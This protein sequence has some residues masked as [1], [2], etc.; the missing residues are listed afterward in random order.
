MDI[1]AVSL[2]SLGE[3]SSDTPRQRGFW[4]SR[5]PHIPGIFMN[6]VQLF[7][8]P[9]SAKVEDERMKIL[10][11]M[12]EGIWDDWSVPSWSCTA[13]FRLPCGFEMYSLLL[14]SHFVSTQ[15][16]TALYQQ[17]F[18][19][20]VE[21][22]EKTR[23]STSV[24]FESH[25]ES[26]V[27]MT[28][29]LGGAR[30][31]E[32]VLMTANDLARCPENVISAVN[33]MRI[34]ELAGIRPIVRRIRSPGE[35]L[36]S[37]STTLEPGPFVFVADDGKF[38]FELPRFVKA[39]TTYGVTGNLTGGLDQQ[40][41][42]MWSLFKMGNHYALGLFYRRPVYVLN[43]VT[44][45]GA[46]DGQ[47]IACGYYHSEFVK[48]DKESNDRPPVKE[49]PK[50]MIP[51]PLPYI[52][53]V[54]VLGGIADMSHWHNRKSETGDGLISRYKTLLECFMR[55]P[56]TFV[57]KE[58][59]E[60]HWET[61]IPVLAMQLY[62]IPADIAVSVNER[63]SALLRDARNVEVYQC[64]YIDY[65]RLVFF[66]TKCLQ[67]MKKGDFENALKFARNALAAASSSIFEVLVLPLAAY[68]HCVRELTENFSESRLH[69]GSYLETL[70]LFCDLT[71]TNILLPEHARLDVS[72]S[73][74]GLKYAICFPHAE[75]AAGNCRMDDLLMELFGL[76]D[77]IA[78]DILQLFPVKKSWT[79]QSKT[80]IAYQSRVR[81][82]PFLSDQCF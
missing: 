25:F 44:Q 24:S 1:L 3:R 56:S 67:Q 33:G 71:N 76:M 11:K 80:F 39:N 32:E 35:I 70:I 61:M 18:P 6:G 79:G 28:H 54:L 16:Y 62:D 4:K 73:V 82:R 26:F 37:I 52:F 7:D 42:H 47:V 9:K 22:Y 58:S 36:E 10:D 68:L 17:L 77:I 15:K 27:K 53:K 46:P 8:E 74:T 45:S 20:F 48:S 66:T 81:A 21:T 31:I 60:E 19:N 78:D 59:G 5:S 64:K 57:Y 12:T 65:T 30:R 75:I 41:V 55:R 72:P 13:R 40:F 50:L 34:L 49:K 2:T 38:E 69:D 29:E 23:F 51:R 63:A 43:G 14:L